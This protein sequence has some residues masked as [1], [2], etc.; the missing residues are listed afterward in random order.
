[1][2]TAIRCRTFSSG[3][4][5]KLVNNFQRG[6]KRVLAQRCRPSSS[7]DRRDLVPLHATD[8]TLRRHS[9]C[10]IIQEI[11]AL[12][13][14]CFLREREEELLQRML[15]KHRR[16]TPPKADSA[17]LRAEQELEIL[18]RRTLVLRR[19]ELSISTTTPPARKDPLISKAAWAAGSA[20]K[21][22]GDSGAANHRIRLA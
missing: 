3:Q 7:L 9:S 13:A 1:M 12:G 14:N 2:V 4:P 17:T 16:P 15:L 22:S 20:G 11:L 10:E 21:A 6:I 18:I 8:S 5:F 19:A